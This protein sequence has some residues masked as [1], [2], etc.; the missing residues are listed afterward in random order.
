V[1][2]DIVDWIM[3]L[4]SEF[5]LTIPNEVAGTFETPR[6]AVDYIAQRV[7]PEVWPLDRIEDRVL[8]LTA[9]TFGVTRSEVRLDSRIVQDF[10]AG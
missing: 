7:A 8:Q 5:G 2:L 9:A 1:G 6:R 3:E 4:E 10:D